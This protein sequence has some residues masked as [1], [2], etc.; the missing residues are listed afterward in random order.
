MIGLAGA[1]ADIVEV[2]VAVAVGPVG[3][4][5]GRDVA[6]AVAVEVGVDT[7]PVHAPSFVH[8]LSVDGL[9]AEQSRVAGISATAW[10]SVLL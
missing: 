1:P 4:A 7:V 8:Q 3:V 9:K 2:A 10:Y 5:V 6:V